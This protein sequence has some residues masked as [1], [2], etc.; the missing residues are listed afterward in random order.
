MTKFWTCGPFK[1][2]EE[3]AELMAFKAE[4]MKHLL[5]VIQEL[6][7]NEE[8]L[9]N[10]TDTEKLLASI[11]QIEIDSKIATLLGVPENGTE[12]ENDEILRK[13]LFEYIGKGPEK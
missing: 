13:V 2:A 3:R 9:E 6:K 12:K 7:S 8:I 4:Q 11:A 10:G 5:Q 1:E